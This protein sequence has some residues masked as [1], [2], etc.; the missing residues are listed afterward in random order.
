M[1]IETFKMQVLPNEFLW[2]HNWMFYYLL[3]GFLKNVF[4]LQD[5]FLT[6]YTDTD[7]LILTQTSSA[8]LYSQLPTQNYSCTLHKNQMRYGYTHQ[9]D[10]SIIVMTLILTNMNAKQ[11]LQNNEEQLSDRKTGKCY[12]AFII[13]SYQLI[14]F[15]YFFNWRRKWQPTPVF[16]SGESHGQRSLAGYSPW[17]HKSQTRLGD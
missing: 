12:F 3:S 15:I 17:G 10:N 8:V 6:F 2:M 13:K 16:L 4:D 1:S 9:H 7:R 14:T 5:A 11:C